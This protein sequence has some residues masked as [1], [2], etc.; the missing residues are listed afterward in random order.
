MQVF[1]VLGSSGPWLAGPGTFAIR[2]LAKG[3]RDMRRKVSLLIKGHK[4]GEAVQN[5]LSRNRIEK[6][7]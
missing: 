2:Q 1:E 5:L 6:T 7:D 3:N 4:S